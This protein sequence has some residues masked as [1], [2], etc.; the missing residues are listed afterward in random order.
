M[1]WDWI[2][3]AIGGAVG[4]AGLYFGWLTARQSREHTERLARQTNEH[5]RLLSEQADAHARNMEQD[6]HDHERR[7]A[8]EQRRQQRLADAYLEIVATAVRTSDALRRDAGAPE[9]PPRTVR[10]DLIRA[11]ALADTFASQEVL[12][13]FAGWRETVEKILIADERLTSNPKVAEPGRTPLDMHR[14]WHKQARDLRLTEV[15]RR[16]ALTEA[17]A[18]ELGARQSHGGGTVTDR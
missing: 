5:S 10:S 9:A 6:R 13:L 1:A 11:Q 4:V 15:D 12:Q 3:P 18:A 16:T 8:E 17:A 2:S 14:H 7:M